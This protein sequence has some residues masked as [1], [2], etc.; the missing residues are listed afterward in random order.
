LV[1]VGDELDGN[2]F[3]ER[4]DEHAALF[5]DGVGPILQAFILALRG[6]GEGAAA[7]VERADLDL[8]RSRRGVGGNGRGTQS[9]TGCE[10]T[11]N[12]FGCAN[13]HE[14]LQRMKLN[15]RVLGASSKCHDSFSVWTLRKAVNKCV[16][17]K[18]NVSL[19]PGRFLEGAKKPG[20]AGP[21]RAAWIISPRRV[22]GFSPPRLR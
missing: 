4:L 17:L 11:Q 18:R 6:D 9:Q 3:V 21:G 10:V 16:D 22:C 20:W 7:G 1:V 12:F 13:G 14:S 2:L 8:R 19:A 5:V 15:R